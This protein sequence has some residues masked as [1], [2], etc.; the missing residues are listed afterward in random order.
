[1]ICILC[2]EIFHK[3]DD[4]FKLCENCQ[5]EIIKRNAEKIVN[6]IKDIELCENCGKVVSV[7]MLGNYW[8]TIKGFFQN[9]GNKKRLYSWCSEKCN[10]EYY[11]KHK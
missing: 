4:N 7:K 11:K 1:M 9:G 8:W 6:G 2:G 10:D 3:Y 5:N